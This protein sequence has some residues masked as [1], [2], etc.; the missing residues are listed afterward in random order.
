MKKDIF[1]PADILLPDGIS[2]E[3]W[4]VIA[5]DQFSSELDYWERVRAKVGNSPSTLNMIIPEAYLS[6]INIEIEVNKIRDAMEMCM[7]QGLLREIKDSFIL[8]ERTLPDGRVRRGL[9]GAVDLDEYDYSGDKAA[10]LAS[11]GTVLDRLPVRVQ[12]RRI[13]RLELPHIIAFINDSEMTVIEPLS[14]KA[15]KLPLLYD[16]ALME[17]GGRISGRRVCDSDADEIMASMR[18]LHEK[19][20]SLMIMGDGNHSLAAA[21]VYWDEL[22]QSYNPAERMNHPARKALLEINNVYDPSI[23]FEAIHRVVFNVDPA[24]FVS[25]FS[26]AMP[27][28]SDYRLYWFSRG[29]SGYIEVAADYIG[30]MLTAM[31]EFID[32]YA[33][34]TGCHVDYIHGEDTVKKLAVEERCLG[35]VLPAMDKNEFFETVTARGAFPKKSFSVGHAKDKRYYL[36]CREIMVRSD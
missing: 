9:V 33:S 3:D 25:K 29:E 13:V 5:C 1:T 10:I 35:L 31:Q 4:S 36:E 24:D 8:V 2:L 19:S 20:D 32:E 21:K 11:E 14:Y 28:G 23:S 34:Q 17:G 27:A 6:D 15:D 16:F 7:K 22:K 18:A 26:R 30:D 12:V